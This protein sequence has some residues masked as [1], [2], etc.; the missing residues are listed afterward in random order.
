VRYLGRFTTFSS[1]GLDAFTLGHCGDHIA[2]FWNVVGHVGL[3]L[4]GVWLGFYL[5]L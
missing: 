5:G 1:F 2:A 3:G 4:G